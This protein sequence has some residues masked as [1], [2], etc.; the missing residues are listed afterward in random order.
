MNYEFLSHRSP[1]LTRGKG[2]R[3][4]LVLVALLTIMGCGSRVGSTTTQLTNDT[5]LPPANATTLPASEGQTS[6]ADVVARVAPAVVT[7]RS[8]RRVRPAQQHPFIDDPFFRQFFGDRA[9]REQQQQPQIQR[10]LR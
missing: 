10:G 7:V 8:E 4:A 6:Y 9:P 5:G 1:R 3:L 2:A